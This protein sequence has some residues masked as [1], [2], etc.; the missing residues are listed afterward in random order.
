MAAI[1]SRLFLM[2]EDTN[3]QRNALFNGKLLTC[4][5]AL[6]HQQTNANSSSMSPSQ[7]ILW[8]GEISINITFPDREMYLKIFFFFKM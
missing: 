2:I 3:T 4:Y 1:L 6:S 7:R 8:N 5:M